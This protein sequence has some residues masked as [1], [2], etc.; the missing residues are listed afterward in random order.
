MAVPLP[1]APASILTP[2]FRAAGAYT[3]LW[4]TLEGISP[5]PVSAEEIVQFDYYISGE[6]TAGLVQEAFGRRALPNVRP[7][8]EAGCNVVRRS[9]FFG[10]PSSFVSVDFYRA[11]T[12]PRLCDGPEV[13]V[14]GAWFAL[15]TFYWVDSN[16]FYWFTVDPERIV[17]EGP[18]ELEE[19]W[20]TVE[21][22]FDELEEQRDTVE[23]FFAVRDRGTLCIMWSRRTS[24]ITITV[25]GP[26]PDV[27]VEDWRE[28][29]SSF[30]NAFSVLGV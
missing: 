5:L 10:G 27:A 2:P 4:V 21:D 14:G 30:S 8:P 1:V 6:V 3:E 20:D 15:V 26:A 9:Q 29:D 18:D 23:D 24:P 22:F 7:P 13:E 17:P 12:G 11:V 28:F 16:S 25:E 19:Q